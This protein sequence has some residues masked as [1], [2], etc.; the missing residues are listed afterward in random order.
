MAAPKSVLGE[1]H[2]ALAQLM[3]N[4]LRWYMD[5]DPPIPLQA[6]DKAAMAKFLKDND[7][8]CDPADAADGA[9]IQVGCK[10]L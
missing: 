1:L 3:L 10:R 6:A 7:I 2:E 8:T 4:E 9:T 5:Q